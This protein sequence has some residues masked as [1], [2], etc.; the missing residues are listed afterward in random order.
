[1]ETRTVGRMQ[2]GEVLSQAWDLYKRF[3]KEFFLTAFIVFV[4]LDLLSALAEQRGG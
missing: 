4:V 1:M 3:L 2:I